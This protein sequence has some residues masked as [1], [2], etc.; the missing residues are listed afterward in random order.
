MDKAKEAIAIFGRVDILINNAGVSSRGAGLD[1]S[2]ET[3][4]KVM[5]VNFFGTAAFTKG[6]C[7]CVCVCCVRVNTP[8]HPAQVLFPVCWIEVVDMS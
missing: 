5:E 4:R 8:L 3:D 1:T 2:I 6:V 7:V